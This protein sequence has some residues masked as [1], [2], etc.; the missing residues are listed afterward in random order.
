MPAPVLEF[1]TLDSTNEEAK[2]RLAA[3]RT[4]ECWLRCDRQTAGYGRRGRAW[5]MADGNLAATRILRAAAPLEAL[6]QLG[7]VAGLAVA[8]AADRFG[9]SAPARLK[10]PNDVMIGDAK[11]AGVLLEL[12]GQGEEKRLLVGIGVNLAAAPPA[13]RPTATLGIAPPPSPQA[14]LTTLAGEFEARLA[15]WRAQ[16]FAPIRAEWMA[17]AYGRDAPLTATMGG[18]EIEGVFRDLDSDGALLLETPEGA[19]CR[20]GAG[21]VFFRSEGV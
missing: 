19:R 9:P 21:D 5:A 20:I 17:R 2:R 1:E 4:K 8:D 15:L 10:W 12:I 13:D 16:G 7:F 14:F 3:G 6:A 18:R 11:A